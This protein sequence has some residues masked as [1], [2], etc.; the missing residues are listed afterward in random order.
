MPRYRHKATHGGLLTC[1]PPL[2]NNMRRPKCLRRMEVKQLLRR[3]VY[4]GLKIILSF[5]CKVYLPSIDYDDLKEW[6]ERLQDGEDLVLF[7]VRSLAGF[8]RG[9]DCET[10]QG[11]VKLLP[12]SPL[13]NLA[14]H[15]QRCPILDLL[16]SSMQD[17]QGLQFPGRLQY[18]RCR[19]GNFYETRI[20]HFQRGDD[21]PG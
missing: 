6:H 18:R 17:Q 16:M 4:Q 9:K 21:T 15:F 8:S 13:L 19:S 11:A 5:G 1:E 14:G 2:V 10:Q 12:K 3:S 20:G 7:D